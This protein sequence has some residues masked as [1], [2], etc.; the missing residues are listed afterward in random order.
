MDVFL[1]PG[2][3]GGLK[4]DELR[5]F[6]A[7]LYTKDPAKASHDKRVP[8]PL[9]KLF[10][11]INSYRAELV[12]ANPALWPSY[13]LSMLTKSPTARGI[14]DRW[15][16]AKPQV[17]LNKVSVEAKAHLMLMS[18]EDRA[19]VEI[20]YF[21]AKRPTEYTAAEGAAQVLALTRADDVHR[22]ISPLVPRPPTVRALDWIK[23]MPAAV[24]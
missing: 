24:N 4:G 13:T 18:F 1:H 3:Q 20:R 21:N 5:D 6:V 23:A 15:Q 14:M 12:N 2:A 22:A 7:R 11:H 17:Q 9:L 19:E 16:E 8:W 10:W